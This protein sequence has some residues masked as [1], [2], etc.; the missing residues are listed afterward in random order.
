M[1]DMTCHRHLPSSRDFR[2]MIEDGN[3]I[4]ATVCD[5]KFRRSPLPQAISGLENSISQV[6]VQKNANV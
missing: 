1:F 5:I 4:E 2:I 6:V 3:K